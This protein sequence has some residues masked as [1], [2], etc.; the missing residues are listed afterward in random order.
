MTFL[1]TMNQRIW[2]IGDSIFW[3]YGSQAQS[4]I[5]FIDISTIYSNKNIT[6]IG[7]IEDQQGFKCDAYRKFSCG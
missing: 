5:Q 1:A 7:N 2:M 6:F 4:I 3:G